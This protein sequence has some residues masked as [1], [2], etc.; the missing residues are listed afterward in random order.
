MFLHLCPANRGPDGQN[1]VPK[2]GHK[3]KI[4][5]FVSNFFVVKGTDTDT[6][7]VF[8]R[9]SWRLCTNAAR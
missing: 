6:N 5:V 8:R 1:A 2:L 7:G 4:A 3:H 9:N